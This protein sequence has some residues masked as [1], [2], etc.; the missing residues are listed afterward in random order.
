MYD[1]EHD[2]G[3]GGRSRRRREVNETARWGAELARIPAWHLDAIPLPDH[4][5]AAVDEA[6]R[7]T[8]HRA[9]ERQVAFVDGLLRNLEPDEQ[10]AIERALA[11][12]G[13]APVAAR[14]N[15]WVERLI[16]GGDEAVEALLAERSD[17]ERQHVRQL[18]RQAKKTG[19][20]DGL[21]RLLG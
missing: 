18:V 9:R 19:K 3:L 21:A 10:A 4:V 1:E 17:L 16:T 2:D 11:K 8:S 15:P 12:P 20:R 6:R 7:I 14:E 13:A 5:R